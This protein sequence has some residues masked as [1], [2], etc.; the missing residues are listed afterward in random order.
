[1]TVTDLA[2]CPVV[3]LR[4]YTLHAD[5][6]ADLIAIFEHHLVEAQ[7][8]TGMIV[9]GLFIDEDDADSFTWLRGF[10][11]HDERV[12][13]LEAFYRGPVWARHSDS[14]NATMVDSDDVLLLRPTSPPH[15]PPGA[16]PRGRANAAPRPERVLLGTCG[17][18]AEADA[19]EPWFAATA[20][21]ALQDVLGVQVATWRT[22][23]TPN[24][25]P[26]LPVRNER[27]LAWLAVFA[28]D[29]TRASAFERLTSD[30]FL[31]DLDQRTAWHR[32]HRLLPTARSAHPTP[33]SVCDH[34]SAARAAP[35][36][37]A[38]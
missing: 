25:F 31:R 2:I 20:H 16:V 19:T 30:A 3:E 27:T 9:G 29:T 18:T 12:R 38:Q 32:I 23:P 22:D 37:A 1:M 24:R 14:A 4:R 33:A 7:E 17:L 36:P 8:Q 34:G 28:D 21:A 10:P 11:S 35:A 13:S 26:Q 6:F 5:A 15:P